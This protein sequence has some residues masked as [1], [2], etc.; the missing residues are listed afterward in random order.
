MY[1]KQGH[2]KSGG[3]SLSSSFSRSRL[4][5]HARSSSTPSAPTTPV[6]HHGI[7]VTRN[8]GHGGFGSTTPRNLD[9]C[10]TPRSS[11]RKVR[12]KSRTDSLELAK[13]SPLSG[14]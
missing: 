12:S 5:H 10:K 8:L 14:K 4:H 2:P 9:S 3:S 7:V 13:G 1:I 6:Q 11:A